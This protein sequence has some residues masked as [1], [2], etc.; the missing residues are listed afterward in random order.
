M[1]NLRTGEALSLSLAAKDAFWQVVKDCLIDIHGLSPSEAQ[2]RSRDLRAEIESPPQ[3]LSSDIFYHA[4]P[5]DVA[6]DLA[7]NQLDVLQYR[8]QYDLILDR[9]NW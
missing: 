5:F 7:G 9:H 8:S 6:C 1:S 2:K 3:G 4:E